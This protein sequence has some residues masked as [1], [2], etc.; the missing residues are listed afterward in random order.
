MLLES[1][2]EI[3]PV[4]FK[5]NHVLKKRTAHEPD[6]LTFFAAERFFELNGNCISFCHNQAPTNHGAIILMSKTIKP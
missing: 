4:R 6:M 1:N 2:T 5:L 3:Y